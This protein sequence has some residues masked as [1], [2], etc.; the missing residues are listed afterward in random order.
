LISDFIGIPLPAHYPAYGIEHTNA[1]I[2]IIGY[3]AEIRFDN[4]R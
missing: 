2:I 3:Y 4:C 1:A